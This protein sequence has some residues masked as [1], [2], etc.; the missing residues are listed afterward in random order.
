MEDFDE[1]LKFVFP[2]NLFSS[3]DELEIIRMFLFSNVNILKFGKLKICR[4]A[5]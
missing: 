1:L 4:T 5:F 3:K 2:E